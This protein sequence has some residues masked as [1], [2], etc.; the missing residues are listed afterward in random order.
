LNVIHDKPDA[1]AAGPKN[2][3]VREIAQ[4]TMR[5]GKMLHI[6]RQNNFSA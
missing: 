3:E 4:K 2:I 1:A 6:L 5:S